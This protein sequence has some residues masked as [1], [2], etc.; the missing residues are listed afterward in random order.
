MSEAG[1]TSE[2]L[3]V[4]IRGLRSVQADLGDNQND[5]TWSIISVETSKMLTAREVPKVRG[6]LV[7]I[8]N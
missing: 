3:E 2:G 8:D 1:Y 6:Y 7:T 4:G 5:R